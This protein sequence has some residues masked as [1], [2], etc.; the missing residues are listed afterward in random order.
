M[1]TSS[2]QDRPLRAPERSWR[3]LARRWAVPA[4]ATVLMA[5]GVARWYDPYLIVDD[6]FIS[7]RF[8]DNLARGLGLV[9]NAGERVEGYSNFLWTVLLA[10]GARAGLDIVQLSIVLALLAAFATVVLLCLWSRRI[11]ERGAPGARTADGLLPALLVALPPLLFAAT[12]SQA[13]YVV[14]GLETLLFGFLISWAAFLLAECRAP[15]AAGCVFGLAAMTRPEG[16][17]YGAA[18]AAVVLLAWQERRRQVLLLGAGLLALLLPYLAWRWSYYGDLLPNTYYA[19]AAGWS[20]ARMERGGALLAEVAG[21]WSV[22]PLALAALCA[23]PAVRASRSLQ[24]AAAFV[25]VTPLYFV[26]VGGD[27]LP[28]F[29]PRF[30]M[31]ALPALLLLAAAGLAN[32]ARWCGN[33]PAVGAAGAIVLAANALWLAWPARHFHRA[34]LAAMMESW[35]DLGR[36]IGSATP[37]ATVI[38][39]GGAGIVPFYSRRTNIDMY[40]LA[41]RHIGHMAPLEIGFKMVAHE[42]Y[43]PR[44]V[45]SRKPDL[46]ITGLDRR[47]TPRTAGLARVADWM[48]ACYR[49]WMLLRAGRGPDGG[50]LLPSRVFNATLFDAGFHTAVLARRTGRGAATCAAYDARAAAEAGRGSGDA[51]GVR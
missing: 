8:A 29:G 24:L 42:K 16:A 3:E 23:L 31:P 45:L 5:A 11:F 38:A 32:L 30:L 39:D 36:W 10:A 1:P 12:G 28:F 40:G 2:R 34:E 48:W 41:D 14:S 18:A 4:A 43:D 6:A 21:Q 13:R 47:R 50:W 27:F 37:P 49:P 17:M 51:G 46:L 19:K 15:L 22:Y 44:Y 35:E 20:L 33:R 25:A 7:F 9:Y 26:A